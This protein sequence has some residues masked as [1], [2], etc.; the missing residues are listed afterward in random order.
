L[1]K[2]EDNSNENLIILYLNNKKNSGKK[3]KIEKRIIKKLNSHKKHWFEIVY[4]KT[5]LEKFE[6]NFIKLNSDPLK[7]FD[8]YKKNYAN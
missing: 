6:T 7:I 2:E 1:K 8:Y 3:N 5:D 4:K